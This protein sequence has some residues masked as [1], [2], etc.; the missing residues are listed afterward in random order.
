[1]EIFFSPERIYKVLFSL[2]RPWKLEMYYFFLA[3]NQ[4]HTSI[5]SQLQTKKSYS[6]YQFL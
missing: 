5:I 2:A 3:S 4:L 1:M 6:E